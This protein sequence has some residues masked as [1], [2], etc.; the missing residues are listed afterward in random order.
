MTRYVRNLL[1]WIARLDPELRFTFFVHPHQAIETREEIENLGLTRV[2]AEIE[3]IFTLRSARFDLY[4]QPWSYN[5]YL[6]RRGPIVVTIHDVT[7][8]LFPDQQPKEWFRRYKLLRRFRRGASRADLILSDSEFTRH[9]ITRRLRVPSRRI[10]V[11]WLGADDFAPGDPAAAAE[12]VRG[13]GVEGPYILYVGGHEERKNLARLVRAFALLRTRC[14]L[15]CRLVLAGPVPALPVEVGA[16][17]DDEGVRDA[18][19]YFGNVT[20]QTLQALYRAARVLAYPSVYEGFG[21]PILEAMASAT[22]VV[23]ASASC[24]PEVAGDAA[25]YF[26]P[27]SADELAERLRLAVTD[28]PLRRQLIARGVVRAAQFRWEETARITLEAFGTVVGRSRKDAPVADPLPVQD[29][30]SSWETNA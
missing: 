7:P 6:P 16:L 19:H 24:L 11:A 29:V 27:R 4:W 26:D 18:A 20:D 9:E 8:F 14:G 22:P 1:R 17:L 28:E 10:R 13:L 5:K 3:S 25:L 23:A 30:A 21:L 12:Q 2:R 15:D